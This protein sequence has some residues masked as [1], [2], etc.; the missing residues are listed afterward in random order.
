MSISGGGA[1]QIGGTNAGAGNVISGNALGGIYLTSGTG[2]NLI[3]GNLIGLT[4]AGNSALGNYQDGIEISGGTGNIIGGTVAGA[5][6]VISGNLNNGVDIVLVTDSGNLVQGNYIGTDITGSSPFGNNQSGI[7]I[8]GCS[9]LIGGTVAGAGNVISGNSQNGIG[10]VGNNGNATGNIIQGN[11]IGLTAAGTAA[12][13]NCVS[14]AAYAGIGIST[15]SAN[16]VGGT[17]AGAGNVI[18]GNY[19]EGIFLVG[20]TLSGNTASGNTIQGNFIG[21]DP[22]GTVGLGNAYDGIYLQ[23]AATNQIGGA[24][25]GAGNLI[26]ADQ[27]EGIFLTNA[28]WNVIQ[29][30]LI[31]TKVDGTNKLANKYHNIDLQTGANNNVIGGAAAGA[32]NHLAWASVGYSS[33]LYCGVRVRTGA[34]NDLISGN[35]IFSNAALGIDLGSAGVNPIVACES[36][37]AANAANAG[38]NFPTLSNVYS[39]ASTLVSGNLNSST[40]NTYTLQF[41]ASPVGDPLGYG[42]GQVYL[43]Q[44]NLTL[45]SATCSS[46][47]TAYLPVSVPAGWVVTATATDPNNNTSEF[48]AWVPVVASQPPV[49]GL[50]TVTRPANVP[51][52]VVLSNLATNWSDLDGGSV[53][54][55]NVNL[56]T[57]NGVLLVPLNV[58]TN[59]SG[60]YV[61][62]N[63]AYF[64][65]MNSRN[66]NDQFSYTIT[67]SFG[68]TNIGLVNII[69]AGNAGFTNSITGYAFGSASNVVTAYGIPGYSYILERSTN[70]TVWVNVSTN[71]A[72]TNGVINAPDY[73]QDL[74]GVA[75]SPGFYRFAWQP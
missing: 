35:A 73:F 71:S 30:N 26:S 1:N 29:G 3:Q 21:T 66:V 39:G 4:A 56:V 22:T 28:S 6:N 43:G 48:S 23:E 17:A 42:Q 74:E 10:L 31:G 63:T 11:L 24:A 51:L 65:Y 2:T 57:T 68:G 34:T 5:R 12:L 45:G 7:L 16:L 25:A 18:S 41:F 38:Q 9:N 49:A 75:P 70:L 33:E 62:T 59:S 54:L 64:G 58:I 60:F 44:T 37:V 19:G 69:V 53:S 46:N 52:E 40:G 8:E 32:G 67:D 47:F 55:A 50:M 20:T 13:G 72:G 15:A 36:G 61:I 27:Y 14:S